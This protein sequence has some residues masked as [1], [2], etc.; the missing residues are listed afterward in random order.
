MKANTRLDLLIKLAPEKLH[1]CAAP[2]KEVQVYLFF[3]EEDGTQWTSPRYT[4]PP[5]LRPESQQEL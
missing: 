2:Q 1:A 4:L 5:H 3:D